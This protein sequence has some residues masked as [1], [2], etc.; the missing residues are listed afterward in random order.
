MNLINLIES[1]EYNLEPIQYYFRTFQS[2]YTMI[3]HSHDYFEI[4]YVESG[5]FKVHFDGKDGND[6]FTV[7]EGQFVFLDSDVIHY[8]TVDDRVKIYNFEF[9]LT[10]N[11]QTGMCLARHFKSIPSV[12]DFI[13]NLRKIAIFNDTA[14]VLL[15]LKSIHAALGDTKNTLESRYL[16]QSLIFSLFVNIGK[17]TASSPSSYS[18]YIMKLFKLIDKNLASDLSPKRL[19]KKLNI[20]ESYLHRLFKESTGTSLVNYVNRKRI[21]LA[22]ILL[23]QTD[24]SIIQIA[25]NVGFNTRQNFGQIFRK[26]MG[27]TPSEY[28]TAQRHREYDIPLQQDKIHAQK[29][30]PLPTPPLPNNP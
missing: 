24:D 17:C 29:S 25:V 1:D 18:V 3:P 12:V 14:N 28:R 4:M 22:Q 21:E 2:G 6:I 10:R 19:A 5:E 20:S 16:I 26:Y 9:C 23:T 13:K 7:N 30:Y 11:D 15:I 8:M 27:T